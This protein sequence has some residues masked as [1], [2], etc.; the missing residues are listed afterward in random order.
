MDSIKRNSPQNA[1]NLVRQKNLRFRISDL[2]LRSDFVLDIKRDCI[3][4][5]SL[6]DKCHSEIRWPDLAANVRCEN[7]RNGQNG[8][9]H[10]TLGTIVGRF[11]AC[12][13][14]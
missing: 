9:T 6:L 13:Y 1:V 7:G 4:R 2:N 14:V 11:A 12:S 5:F 3:N 10:I 8:Y